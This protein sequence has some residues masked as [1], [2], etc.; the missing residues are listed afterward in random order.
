MHVK[1]FEFK[2][3]GVEGG[4]VKDILYSVHCTLTVRILYCMHTV[5]ILYTVTIVN[6]WKVMTMVGEANQIIKEALIGQTVTA[7]QEE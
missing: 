6:S 5:S 3:G 1:R 2:C 7:K 4:G